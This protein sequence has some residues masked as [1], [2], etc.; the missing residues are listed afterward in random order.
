MATEVMI[1]QSQ[2]MANP[3]LGTC[4]NLV[5]RRGSSGRRR[6]GGVAARSV[7]VMTAGPPSAST[8]LLRKSCY[9]AVKKPGSR[10]PVHRMNSVTRPRVVADSAREFA[11]TATV[12]EIAEEH[13]VIINPA[14]ALLEKFADMPPSDTGETTAADRLF[15][16]ED[17]PKLG[18]YQP[19]KYHSL[20]S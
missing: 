12:G 19:C 14:E 7:A 3:L 6:F 9:N 1:L 18:N 11:A 4:S 10:S 15:L 16:W 17:V 8:K 13:S 2:A 20:E 5:P